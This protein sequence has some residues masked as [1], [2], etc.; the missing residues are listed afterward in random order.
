[1]SCLAGHAK[2]DLDLG[3]KDFYVLMS[4]VMTE[5]GIDFSFRIDSSLGSS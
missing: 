3:E 1:M 5:K 2:C 4:G